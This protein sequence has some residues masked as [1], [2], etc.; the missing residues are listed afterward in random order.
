M[1]S[2]EHQSDRQP[3]ELPEKLKKDSIIEA[4]CEVRFS[5][6]ELEELV[7]GRLID[8]TPWKEYSRARLPI[9]DIPSP[10]RQADQNLKYQPVFEIRGNG[11]IVKIGGSVISF[12]VLSPYHGWDKFKLFLDQS[13]DALVVK[14]DNISI[15]RIGLR[16]INALVAENHFINSISDL[17]LKISVGKKNIV[18][19]YLN[20]NF[21]RK[22]SDYSTLIRIAS[23]EF[24]IGISNL[25]ALIDIDISTP[26]NFNTTDPSTAKDWLNKAHLVGKEEYF[27][28]IPE[29]VLKLLIEK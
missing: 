15:T 24:V 10:I 22:E 29:K 17:P 12:H 23:P 11:E 20:L 27:N 25:V 5:C 21:M 26:D 2:T 13:I 8:N 19:N 28:L 4:I 16:Y 6:E 7:I 3:F 1:S 18:L 14:I 9:A